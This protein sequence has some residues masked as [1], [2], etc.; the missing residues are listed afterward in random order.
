MTF[1]L[2]KEIVSM[3]MDEPFYAALSRRM[4]KRADPSIPTAGVRFNKEKECFELVYN[5]TF[6]E[7]LTPKQRR[8]VL[9]HE[10]W[11]CALGH[12]SGR[13][14]DGVVF[15]MWNY[16]TDLA[17][18]S[19]LTSGGKDR[20]LL[21][22]GCLLPG[23]S[24]FAEMPHFL[25][26]EKYLALLREKA[27]EEKEKSE[28]DKSEGGEPGES[29][30]GGEPG[31]S[32]EGSG[33]GE[34]QTLDDHSAWEE[35]PGDMDAE[36]AAAREIAE[37]KM[38]QA[39]KEAYEEAASGRGMGSVCSEAK[40][41]LADAIK[42]KVNWKNV[43]RSFVST[44]VRADRKH[45]IRRINKRYP[46]IHAGSKTKREAKIAVCID[47]SGSVDDT[48]LVK[49]YAEL[50]KLCDLVSFDI[51]PFD[52]KVGEKWVYT[53]KKG[54]K[55]AWERVMWGGTCFDAPTEWVNSKKY[56]AM[57]V[58]TDM[59]APKPKRSN[60]KRLWMTTAEYAA[61]PW[62]NPNPEKMLVVD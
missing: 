55:R 26:S 8:G 33:G 61:H 1:D 38:R 29:S 12:V 31:E 43:L 19:M 59:M 7:G 16:A 46:M 4:D 39:V 28:G 51:I 10:L 9:F 49:F 35:G 20:D 3:L 13:I 11:H 54:Q 15:K 44:S 25:T 50:N 23:E 6:F 34:P 24:Q 2:N 14:P 36:E 57:I 45:T 18:N 5:P 40:K 60:C 30:G 47:Q 21:P 58:L 48:M 53:W 62:F 22:E 17:I 56:D 52:T 27:K 32:S 41:L 42:T 37:E